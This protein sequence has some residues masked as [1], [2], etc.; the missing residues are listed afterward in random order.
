MLLSDGAAALATERGALLAGFWD[1]VSAFLDGTDAEAGRAALRETLAH[2]R[3]H[4]VTDDDKT[5]V[6]ARL[7][8]AR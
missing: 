3:T 8:D 2:E 5:V 6:W 4:R 7:E 1:P